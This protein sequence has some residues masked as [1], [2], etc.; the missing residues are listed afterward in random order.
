MEKCNNMDKIFFCEFFDVKCI[1]LLNSKIRRARKDNTC[2]IDKNLPKVQ[3]EEVYCEL[4]SRQANKR[5]PGR[6]WAAR[7]RS[8][9][10]DDASSGSLCSISSALILSQSP[11]SSERTL[12][13]YGS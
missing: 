2:L 7:D 10:A 3:I 12:F 4:S 8:S 5:F 6:T 13:R 1:N 9:A 11:F